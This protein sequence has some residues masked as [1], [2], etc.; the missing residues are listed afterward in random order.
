MGRLRYSIVT[1]KAAAAIPLAKRLYSLAQ[2]QNDPTLMIG[3][4]TAAGGTH[5]HLGD[6]ETAQQ[7]TTRAI[8][9]W[10]S[11]GVGS[12][13]QEVDAQPVAC[14]SHEALL[15][16]HFGEIA[17]CHAT[18]AEAIALAKEL[19]D[20]HGLAVA[21]SYAAR[22]AHFERSAAEVER[23]TSDLIELSTRH[24]FAH[25]LAIGEVF[26]GWGRSASG[27]TAEGLQWIEEGI[28]DYC[29]TG[30]IAWVPYFLALKAEALHLANRTSAALEA[31]TEAKALR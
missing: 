17:A 7:Y 20:M 9:I 1:D 4:C 13:F 11:G 19:N 6:F 18:M 8:Q 10:R 2:E 31:V 23:L 26:R 24:S 14:L 27:N 5:W 15:E 29:A 22:L 30:S 16:W 28:E 25:W 12:P 21:L 3:A